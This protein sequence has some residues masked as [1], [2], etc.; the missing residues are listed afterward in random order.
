MSRSYSPILQSS[1][2]IIL[3]LTLVHWHQLTCVGLQYSL[4]HYFFL[5]YNC[6]QV[7]NNLQ[8]NYI[9]NSAAQNML[10]F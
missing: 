6:T 4:L 10:L 3:S 8:T 1:F 9:Y 7:N 2:N 5:E